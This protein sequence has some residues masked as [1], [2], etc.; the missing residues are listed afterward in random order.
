MGP[1]PL[2]DDALT[3]NRAYQSLWFFKDVFQPCLGVLGVPLIM[4]PDSGRWRSSLLAWVKR[5]RRR[6]GLAEDAK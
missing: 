3:L 1:R 5:E 2:V 4:V 6:R